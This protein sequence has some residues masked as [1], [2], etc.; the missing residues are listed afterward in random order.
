MASLI[1]P[2]GTPY[3]KLSAMQ[4]AFERSYEMQASVAQTMAMTLR[5]RMP[6][7]VAAGRIDPQASVDGVE[8]VAAIYSG[9]AQSIRSL[10]PI[11]AQDVLDFVATVNEQTD[12]V[13]VWGQTSGNQ[14][15]TDE[16]V[17]IGSLRGCED[18]GK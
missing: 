7:V 4:T 3:S 12:A 13:S 14:L 10:A 15:T 16:L 17:F 11:K 9:A 5:G 2:P 6:A 8:N 1:I 18:I